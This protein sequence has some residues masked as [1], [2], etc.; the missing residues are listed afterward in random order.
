MLGFQQETIL[1]WMSLLQNP[2]EQHD[3][4]LRWQSTVTSGA[5]ERAENCAHLWK[6]IEALIRARLCK[7]G[8]CNGNK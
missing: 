4:K 3:G 2:L 5:A 8:L 6:I 1:S 7:G